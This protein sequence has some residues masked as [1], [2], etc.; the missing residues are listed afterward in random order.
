MTLL[1][2]GLALRALCP[3]RLILRSHCGVHMAAYSIFA[4]YGSTASDALTNLL[5]QAVAVCRTENAA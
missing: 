2:Y 5:T 4:G 1:A 3:G